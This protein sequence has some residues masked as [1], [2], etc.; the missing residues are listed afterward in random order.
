[1]LERRIEERR[2]LAYLLGEAW[3]YGL[4]F[5]VDES[6]LVPRSPLAELIAAGF[7]PWL[8]T[9]TIGSALDLCTGSGCI[10]VAMACHLPGVPIDAADISAA[11]LAVARRNV[12]L[13]GMDDR[14]RLVRSDLFK[15][16]HGRRYDLIVSNPPYVPETQLP[17]LPA[18]YRREP[19]LALAAGQDGLALVL[20]I[21]AAAPAHLADDGMLICEVGESAGRLQRRLPFAEFTWLEFE[22]G[23]GGVFT[24]G[25]EALVQLA[26][27]LAQPV[28]PA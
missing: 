20:R 24:I 9:E 3:F 11:A 2:P 27:T 28:A 7:R 5:R 8:K 4:R 21:L 26:E 16:L 18:E 12:A 1:L 6:V 19:V 15:S 17:D 23:G 13:H 10:A 22:H 14:V 25:R